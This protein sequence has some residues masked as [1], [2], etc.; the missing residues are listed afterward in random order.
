VQHHG[1]LF[2]PTTNPVSVTISESI[3]TRQKLS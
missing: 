1:T 3:P 2:T